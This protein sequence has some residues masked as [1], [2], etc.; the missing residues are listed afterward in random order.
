MPTTHTVAQGECLS[1]IAYQFKLA[2][3]QV[4]YDD[5]HN[6]DFKAKRPNPNLIYPAT[7]CI[8]RT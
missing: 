5:P 8:F 1:S 6:A 4:I 3:W 7:N 2:S